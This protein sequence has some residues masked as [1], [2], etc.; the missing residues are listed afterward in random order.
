MPERSTSPLTPANKRSLF[1]LI[2]D[3]PGLLIDL[4]RAEVEQFKAQLAEKGQRLGLGVALIL[5]AAVF[6]FFGLG[7]LVACAV[8]A[9]SLVLPGWLAAL[10]VAGILFAL[11]V[12]L[13]FV[14]RGRIQAGMAKS[15][16]DVDL[17]RDIDAF[18]GE[19]SYDRR[20]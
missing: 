7:V 8:L 19:G 2:G 5:V 9:L 6:A 10:I 17:K 4:A 15:P 13:I 18:K 16:L 3:L 12:L 20:D 14:G 1:A 11:A